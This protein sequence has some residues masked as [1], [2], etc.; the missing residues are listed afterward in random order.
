[1]FN[2]R[3]REFKRSFRKTPKWWG[4][5]HDLLLLDLSLRFNWDRDSIRSE[6][7]NPSKKPHYQELLKKKK[8]ADFKMEG[9][10]DGKLDEFGG[11]PIYDSMEQMIQFLEKVM[12]DIDQQSPLREHR[13][14]VMQWFQDQQCGI[15]EW[16]PMEKMEFIQQ[17]ETLCGGDA[18]PEEVQKAAGR[19]Y[20]LINMEVYVDQMQGSSTSGSSSEEED[21]SK[22]K[23]K[24]RPPLPARS[25]TFGSRSVGSRSFTYQSM[26]RG[27][28]VNDAE[29]RGYC[30]VQKVH[31]HFGG[32]DSECQ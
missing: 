1:M 23:E 22:S 12:K 4:R 7:S 21:E 28:R 15:D 25:P 27:R 19:L 17:M 6:L 9:A 24:G 29:Y 20:N 11:D 26:R 3:Y 2:E 5:Q 32:V 14:Q 8:K 13:Q 31:I 30:V 18:E 10:A 16:P